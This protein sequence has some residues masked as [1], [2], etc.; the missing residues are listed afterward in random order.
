MIGFSV[1]DETKRIQRKLKADVKQV[2]PALNATLNRMGTTIRKEGVKKL[3]EVTGL[4]QKKLRESITLEKSS[5]NRLTAKV[6]A[7]GRPHNLSS[8]NARVKK[9]K[10]KVV[11]VTAKPW[12]K[13]HFFKGLFIL[14][15][16]GNPVLKRVGTKLK[17]VYGPGVARE[18]MKRIIISLYNRTALK[19]FKKE[20][21]RQLKYR[22]S[23]V[24]K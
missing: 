20:F 14:P 3:A 9:V 16:A 4:K 11:G 13:K 8:F 19:V 23:K 2:K 24:K 15:V 21:E 1:T 7:R 5:V 10:K 12:G 18:S 17:G 22:M 6:V